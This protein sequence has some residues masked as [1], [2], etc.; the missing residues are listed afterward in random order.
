MRLAARIVSMSWTPRLKLARSLILL[1]SQ[2]LCKVRRHAEVQLL[3]VESWHLVMCRSRQHC[4]RS[5]VESF[6]ASEIG[7]DRPDCT[8][9]CLE[10]LGKSITVFAGSLQ[11]TKYLNKTGG[12]AHDQ[13]SAALPHQLWL[14]IECECNFLTKCISCVLLPLSVPH[15]QYKQ[16]IAKRARYSTHKCVFLR[17]KQLARK[18]CLMILQNTPAV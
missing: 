7:H 16:R 17:H 5:S 14:L 1:A 10:A 6:G 12:G 15:A 8:Y 18:V 4:T 13:R 3:L 2:I 9:W 11:S